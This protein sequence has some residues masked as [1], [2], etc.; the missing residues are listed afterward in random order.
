MKVL[1]INLSREVLVPGGDLAVDA[2]D[3]PGGAVGLA[4]LEVKGPAD[5]AK[6]AVGFGVVATNATGD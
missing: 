5:F 2:A 4:G 6:G 1:N 3:Q